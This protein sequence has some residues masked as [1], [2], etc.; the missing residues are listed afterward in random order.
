MKERGEEDDKMKQDPG[1][2]VGQK[3]KYAAFVGG[4][5]QQ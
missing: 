1:R 5:R 2:P 4:R 3:D